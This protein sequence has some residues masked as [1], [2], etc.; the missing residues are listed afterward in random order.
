MIQ[1]LSAEQLEAAAAAAVD[2]H[3]DP[4]HR[5]LFRLP[6]PNDP[7]YLGALVVAVLLALVCVCFG[8]DQIKQLFRRQERPRDEPLEETT[9]AEARVVEL[10][11]DGDHNTTSCR[12]SLLKTILSTHDVSNSN[13][14]TRALTTTCSICLVELQSGDEAFVAPTCRHVFHF[15]C[16][17]SWVHNS[18]R[19]SHG[20][21]CPNCRTQL[22]MS[23]E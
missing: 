21:D 19:S 2:D 18:R 13:D 1:R 8:M 16:M 9:V 23:S 5:L 17:E 14:S 15:H 20:K 4:H 11:S 22:K 7:L 12:M 10:V 3:D 6:E